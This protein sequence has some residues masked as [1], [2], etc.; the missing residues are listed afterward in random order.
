[1]K[2][3]RPKLHPATCFPAR[4][5]EPD[6]R[7]R[8]FIRVAGSQTRLSSPRL[9]F[10]GVNASTYS[11]IAALLVSR[12]RTSIES[13]KLFDIGGQRDAH[14]TIDDLQ[15]V[16]SLNRTRTRLEWVQSFWET[17]DSTIVVIHVQHHR[18]GKHHCTVL[19]RNT[20]QCSYSRQRKHI[21]MDPNQCHSGRKCRLSTTSLFT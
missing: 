3:N 17:R 8:L 1:M 18:L 6:T 5:A 7:N 21:S 11:T 20:L 4:P 19:D 14:A 2:A 12:P 13:I 10:I 15:S 9:A 16:A